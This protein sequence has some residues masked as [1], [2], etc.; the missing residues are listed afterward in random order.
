M[1]ISFENRT[2]LVTGASTGIGA[3]LAVGYGACGGRVAVHY[4]SSEPAP[5]PPPRSPRRCS[6]GPGPSTCW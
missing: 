6:A 5:R 2:V 1:N 4:N 3:A